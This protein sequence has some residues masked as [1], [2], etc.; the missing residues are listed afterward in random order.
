MSRLRSEITKGILRRD[1]INAEESVIIGTS[2]ILGIWV[3]FKFNSW[4]IFLLVVILSALLCANKWTLIARCIFIPFVWGW[5][6][7]DAGN[8]YFFN[9]IL[10]LEPWGLGVFFLVCSMLFHLG[11]ISENSTFEKHLMERGKIK[12][13]VKW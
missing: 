2:L 1:E 8:L 6:W 12:E 5:L 9:H 13:T 11:A 10:G 3:G 7:Y 4:L